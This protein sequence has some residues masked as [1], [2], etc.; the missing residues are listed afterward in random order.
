MT[1]ANERAPTD[2]WRAAV[3]RAAFNG[4]RHGYE[5]IAVVIESTDWTTAREFVDAGSDLASLFLTKGALG[6]V[7]VHGL[8][9]VRPQ[10][11]ATLTERWE[12]ICPTCRVSVTCLWDRTLIATDNR[13]AAHGASLAIDRVLLQVLRPWY[14]GRASCGH[15]GAAWDAFEAAGGPAFVRERRERRQ[16]RERDDAERVARSEAERQTA[17]QCTPTASRRSG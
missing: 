1:T 8:A 11:I 7:R 9:I 10:D 16:Q 5:L 17:E 14:R 4:A 12:A 3:M 2:V 15:L 13:D 6:S